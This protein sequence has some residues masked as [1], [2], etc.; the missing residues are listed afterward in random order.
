VLH[1]DAKRHRA[2]AL[3]WVGAEPG[4][5][6]YLGGLAVSR[7]KNWSEFRAA[8]GAWKLPCENMVYADVDGNIGWVATALTPI[9]KGWD[10]LLPVPGAEGKYEWQGFLDLD[11]L[12]QR[13]NPPE[14]YIATANHNILPAGFRDEIAYEWAPTYR[15]A[16]IK[17]RLDAKR[18]FDLADF[19]SIQH[20]NTS[21]AGQALARLVRRVDTRN[22]SLRPYAKMLASWD[23]ELTRESGAGALYGFWLRELVEAFYEPRVPR[24]SL[25]SFRSHRGAEVMLA[26][27]ENPDR[28][29]FGDDP[30]VRR[31]E[32]LQRTFT[33]AVAKT[34]AALGEDPQQWAWGKLHTM[35][36]RHPLAGLGPAHE[37]A[38]SLGR[39][40][41]PGD[42]LTPNAASHNEK[43]AQASGA[44]Y[45]QIFD[46]AD[47]DRGLATSVPGQSGQPGSPHYADLLPLWA[48]GQYFPLAFS[49]NKVEEVTRHRL[50]LKPARN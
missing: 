35:H 3:R 24:R 33:S 18:E 5:A 20:D 44:S 1:Q 10:G 37:K 2:Y 4:G 22:P 45:R 50:V 49:R 48:E 47:W 12:P 39:V 40:P 23:G 7:A 21:L 8:L 28:T 30:Q 14:H 19:Q 32:L 31:D 34:K 25:S 6:A 27:L 29:W 41:R 17:E 16:R 36:F 46:L 13:F 15:F 26:A 9:R 43:F 42:G 11:R 38:L